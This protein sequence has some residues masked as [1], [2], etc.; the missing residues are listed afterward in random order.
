MERTSIAPGLSISRVLTGMWQVADLERSGRTLDLESAA[1]AL[2]PYAQAGVTSFDMA[3]HYGSAE[4][5]AGAF[6]QRHGPEHPVELLT[7]W[8]P[9]PGAVTRATTRAAVEKALARLQR[10]RIDLLQ[11]HTWTYDDPAWLDALGW[12]HELRDE[13]L[14]RAIGVT[15][16]DAAHLRVALATGFEIVTDQVSFSLLDR[17]AAG[18]LSAL[19]ATREVKLLAYGTLAGGLL[20][21]RWLGV[22][23]PAAG[24]LD[25]WSL[26][27]YRRF[28]A[29]AGGWEP[30]QALLRAVRAVAE[31]RG[32]SMA[33]V[34]TRWV[35]D[36]PAVAG[37]IIGARLGHSEHV[38]DHVALDTL[39]LDERDR[40][41]LDSAASALDP[42][43]G[44]CGDEYRKPPY[45][46]A[47]GDLSHHLDELPAPYPVTTLPDGR[48]VV[49]TGT[50][51]EPIAGYARAVRIGDRVLVSGT[52]ATHRDGTVGGTD[53]IAQ[54]HFVF[55]KIEGAL[56]SLGASLSDVVRTRV[57]VSRDR[58]VEAVARVHGQR[59]Q[60]VWP[61]NTL[62]VTSLANRGE[63][64]EIEAEA[65]VVAG[66]AT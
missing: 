1:T 27:K 20:T 10:E 44:D 55:D 47:S 33:N 45:L 63:L 58:D 39:A 46:T 66:A 51:W 17:R 29:A 56:R 25:T 61:A 43:R 11:F 57:Y 53:A 41:E 32:V 26:M 24:A 13:G 23:E 34:A 30:Y 18:D 8:V 38:A 49:A 59:L 52:T 35:L 64:V 5:I 9:A 50:P 6:A 2:V 14:V 31:R 48:I 3:D 7:K 37:V 62:L 60:G 36:H 12:L 15:N 28:I 42:I 16:F 21:E 65:T 22:A 4:L 54:T 19:C 40:A